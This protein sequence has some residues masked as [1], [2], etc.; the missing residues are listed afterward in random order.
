MDGLNIFVKVVETGGFS[1]AARALGLSKS[2]VSKQVSRLEDRLGVRL[3]QRTTRK[4]SLTEEGGAFYDRA[5][6]ILDDIIDAEDAV[7]HLSATPKGTLR[8]SMPTIFGNR[9]LMPLLPEFMKLYPDLKIE[10]DLNDRVVDVVNDQFDLAVRITVLPDLSL[11]A[12]KLAPVRMVVCASPDYWAKNGTPGT[13]EDLKDHQ[14]LLYTNLTTR[15]EWHF[16]EKGGRHMRIKINGGFRSNNDDSL[17]AAALAGLGVFYGPAYVLSEDI[18]SNRLEPVL[19][20]YVKQDLN[21]YIVYPNKQYLSS[22]VRAFVDFLTEHF[23]P[24]PYW[25]STT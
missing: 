17:R 16:H 10:T 21:M 2:Q 12:K 5:R 24:E 4:M 22:K 8:I 25:N 13:P 14:C 9:H 18:C 11:I 20:D 1:A 23:G 3:L 6:Q 15:N 7:T 19:A